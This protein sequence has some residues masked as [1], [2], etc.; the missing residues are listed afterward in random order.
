MVYRTGPALGES[1]HRVLDARKVEELVVVDNGSQPDATAAL[2]AAAP[3][4]GLLV[5]F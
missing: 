2:D 3:A 4:A 1:L 5:A